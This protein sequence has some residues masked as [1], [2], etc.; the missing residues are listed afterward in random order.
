MIQKQVYRDILIDNGIDPHRLTKLLTRRRFQGMTDSQK[1]NYLE[2]S[3]ISYPEL[4]CTSFELISK[5]LKLDKSKIFKV[6]QQLIEEVRHVYRTF[7]GDPERLKVVLY[8]TKDLILRFSE[9]SGRRR[10][11]QPYF[12][13]RENSSQESVL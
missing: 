3:D 10:L 2:N 4:R 9:D 12:I 5:H 8:L 6:E 1:L 13:S 7:G 11:E